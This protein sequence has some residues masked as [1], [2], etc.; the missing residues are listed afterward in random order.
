MPL[1][2]RHTHPRR[3]ETPN[4]TMTTLASPSLGPSAG[5]SVWVVE[6]QPGAAGPVHVF[7]SE[8]V[9]SV[10]EGGLAIEL[11]GVSHVLAAGD[12]LVVPGRA[13]RQIRAE[14]RTR[15]IVCGHGDAIVAVP[16]EAADRGTPPWI[17]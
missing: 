12:A 15:A 9:W 5:L 16:G 10:L 17:A 6:M 11:D 4:A 8:Q 2:A 14:A 13:T 1:P 3:H 7:D